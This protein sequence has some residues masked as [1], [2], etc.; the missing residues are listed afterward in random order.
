M[1]KIINFIMEDILN[2]HKLLASDENLKTNSTIRD[3]G[4]LESAVNNPF[5]TFGG[6]DLYPTIFDKAARLAFGLV[7]NHGFV[8]GNKRV[9]IH[10]ME[11]YLKVNNC[12]LKFSQEELVTIGMD[13]AENKLTSEELS[14]LLEKKAILE[15]ILFFDTQVN[16]KN[17]NN[18]EKNKNS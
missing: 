1:K 13:L 5:Q 18:T 14:E 3:I 10:A 8:D 2:F 9:A 11:V 12:N 17:E 15:L 4:L 16:I 7:K 6:E